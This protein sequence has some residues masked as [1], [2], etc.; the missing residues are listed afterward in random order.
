MASQLEHKNPLPGVKWPGATHSDP[1]STHDCAKTITQ[2][3]RA[4]M[5]ILITGLQE[6]I[7]L[8][9]IDWSINS[10]IFLV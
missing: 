9:L 8:V 6:A 7:D 1:L 2:N 5:A 4:S 3:F 10:V